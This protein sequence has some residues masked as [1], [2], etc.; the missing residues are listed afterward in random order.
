MA[1]QAIKEHLSSVHIYPRIDASEL[2]EAIAE[3]VACLPNMIVCGNGVDGVLETLVRIFMDNND[4]AIIP[5]PTF[6]MYELATRIMG[7][8]PRFVSLQREENFALPVEELLAQVN[9]KTRMIFLCSPNNPTGSTTPENQVRKI[10]ESTDA[11][12][13]LDEAYVQFAEGNLS[14]L[15]KEYGNIIITRTFSKAYGLAGLRIGYAIIPEHLYREYMKVHEPFSVNQLAIIAGI[16]ALKDREHL[17]QT[18][19]M[20]RK[21]RDYLSENIRFKT[22][23]S[24]ANFI[25]CDTSPL[26]ST[27]VASELLQQG[28][29]IRDCISFR[30]AGENLI[31]VTVGTDEQ[32]KRVADALNQTLESAY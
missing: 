20:V 10:A 17:E 2:R 24:Q 32:N 13:V 8:T 22:Y 26:T 3:H 28:I 29:I 7:G 19:S 30:G 21:G 31:R 16:A 9:N 4:E 18:I 5:I 15:V 14:N 1:V 11:A 27:Q 25:A 6:S 23:P 12:I